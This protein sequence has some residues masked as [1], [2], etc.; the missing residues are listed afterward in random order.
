[1]SKAAFC[2]GKDL[3]ILARLSG[4]LGVFM[5]SELRME[6][7]EALQSLGE[8]TENDCALV[9]FI[10]REN[11]QV[12]E[13]FAWWKGGPGAAA[14]DSST[15]WE[16]AQKLLAAGESSSGSLFI[17]RSNAPATLPPQELLDRLEMNSLVMQSFRGRNLP[18]GILLL[19]NV[20]AR[21]KPLTLPS[22]YLLS[23]GN[24]LAKLFSV[25][26]EKERN[27]VLENHPIV[28][29]E[30]LDNLPDFLYVKDLDSRFVLA[31]IAQVRLLGKKSKAE[32][33]GK[34]DF[35][36]Y[37]RDL[38]ERYYCDERQ[39]LATGKPL[40]DREEPGLDQNRNPICV[41]TSKIPLH[42]SHGR[43][44]GVLGIGRDITERR[45]LQSE[46]HRT[47]KM[48]SLG[49]IAG[50]IGNELNNLLT[51]LLGGISLAKCYLPPE[52][53]AFKRLT[54]AQEA[55][56]LMKQ[57]SDRLYKFAKGAEPV[58]HPTRL[59]HLLR[60]EVF[61]S[62]STSPAA[63][64][65]DFQ[66]SED[67]MQAEID[68]DQFRQVINHL[69]MN[70]IEAMTKGGELR[71]RAENLP[72]GSGENPAEKHTGA[73][74]I[75]IQIEDKGIGI[76][77][78]FIPKLYDP[79][80]TTKDSVDRKGR[81]LGL[82][83]CH[84]IIKKHGGQLHIESDPGMGTRVRIILPG[85]NPQKDSQA[86]GAVQVGRKKKRILIM[87]DEAFV[88]T[89]AGEMVTHLGFDVEFACD[90]EE[91]V[92]IYR[93]AHAS[94]DPFA[95]VILDLFVSGG[96]G[97]EEAILALRDFDREVKGVVS[98]GY[99]EDP[100]A[101]QYRKYGFIDIIH[102]PFNL[103]QLEEVIRRTIP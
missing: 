30:I 91:A 101:K 16:R 6:I 84:S 81:G 47:R 10:H 69:V 96:P 1:M 68:E 92:E 66:V 80:F 100:V 103:E 34:T 41:S 46:V 24:L 78:E 22:P 45:K 73:G 32:L 35:D 64:H 94:G 42:D 21:Q 40:L 55:G 86:E 36:L 44:I 13:S 29:R 88:R 25:L 51:G 3:H 76:P 58:K 11:G 4:M 39:V 50:G 17:N 60:E 71:V 56:V 20:Q 7:S 67:L 49:V 43:I 62:L 72:E 79:Y 93:K 53:P 59:D 97:G 63:I 70:A 65:C 5:S 9:C 54:Q 75:K 83:V 98:T 23:L 74:Y 19:G 82:P 87:D 89:V 2:T 27:G 26:T 99:G 52:D 102:K 33:V 14:A 95:L 85:I 12:L 28:L 57:L 48:E 18:E 90:G 61:F 8:S 37:P 31:N 77:F 15:L 38:A